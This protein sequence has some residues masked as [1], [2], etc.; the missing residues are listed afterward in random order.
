MRAL[1]GVFWIAVLVLAAAAAQE[2]CPPFGGVSFKVPLLL[3]LSVYAALT[4]SAGRAVLVAVATG[5]A[6]D[7]LGGLPF[8]C[9]MSFHLLAWAGAAWMRRGV[10]VRPSPVY[11]ALLVAL[12]APLQLFWTW[13]WVPDQQAWL[14]LARLLASLP[15]GAL[16][17]AIV[18]R[19][20]GMTDGETP[21]AVAGRRGRHDIG[22]A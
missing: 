17:G 11:G 22:L 8:L 5:V 15:A 2:I 1:V 6:T 13:P 19:I 3:A 9:T 21:R 7:A 14:P 20:A 10:M 12:A 18:F 4:R 16:A